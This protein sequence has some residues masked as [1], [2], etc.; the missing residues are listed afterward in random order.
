MAPPNPG[1]GT[2][3]AGTH[4]PQRSHCGHHGN[5]PTSTC[6][7]EQQSQRFPQRGGQAQQTPVVREPASPAAHTRVQ[8]QGARV[9]P[10]T[11]QRSRACVLRAARPTMPL[12]KWRRRGRSRAPPGSGSPGGG[13]CWAKV[14]AEKWGAECTAEISYPRPREGQDI[15]LAASPRPTA[16]DGLLTCGPTELSLLRPQ[17]KSRPVSPSHMIPASLP[18]LRGRRWPQSHSSEGPTSQAMAPHRHAHGHICNHAHTP[19]HV[20]SCEYTHSH[21]YVYL[22]SHTCVPTM[23]SLMC[24]HAYPHTTAIHTWCCMKVHSTHIGLHTHA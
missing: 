17:R 15:L 19:A 13:G 11:P 24:I 18:S 8:K 21:S 12:G 20:Y 23:L 9:V 2:Q 1:R 3:N 7:S 16:P 14:S 4:W 5:V 6:N 10:S 22:H